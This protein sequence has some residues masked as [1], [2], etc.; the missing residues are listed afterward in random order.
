M[1]TIDVLMEGRKDF[2]HKLR[3][4]VKTIKLARRNISPS[5]NALLAPHKIALLAI[6]RE[7]VKLMKE[8]VASISG[9]RNKVKAARII[10]LAGY[11]TAAKLAYNHNKK[12]F[13]LLGIEVSSVP[14]LDNSY[15]DRIMEDLSK[16][17][18]DDLLSDEIKV[19]RASMTAS[20]AANR[21]YT[22]MNLAMYADVSSDHVVKKVWVANKGLTPPPCKY[23]LKLD[24]TKVAFDQ[25]FPVPRGSKPYIDLQGPPSIHPHCRCRLSIVVEPK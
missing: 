3:H 13:K 2:Y 11:K 14:K 4:E 23:C 22:D 1:T 19:N 18:N 5:M 20:I 9:N 17:L 24:G 7:T 6:E 16:S 25:P 12:E 15:I 10:A 21:G 8:K